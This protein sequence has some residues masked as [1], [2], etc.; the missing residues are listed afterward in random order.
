MHQRQQHQAEADEDARDAARLVRLARHEHQH[1]D[2]DQ[3]GP[4]PFDVER[5]HL[6]DDRRADV[7]TEDDSERER[8]GDQAASRKR[9]EQ[10]RGGGGALQDAGDADAGEEGADAR[11]RIG[12]D[13]ASQRR[14]EG[15][16]HA[17]AHHAHAPEQER[18]TTEERGEQLRAGHYPGKPPTRV[19][20]TAR[21]A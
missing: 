3:H 11:A 17:G 13:R 20:S 2:R 12:R 4:Q 10:H 5:K 18:D 1:A 21:L 14:A 16:R 9:G 19:E 8:Q 15:A 7:G 6:R